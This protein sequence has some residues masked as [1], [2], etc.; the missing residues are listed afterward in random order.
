[1]IKAK[2]LTLDTEVTDKLDKLLSKEGKSISS[3][4]REFLKKELK[5][6]LK[7]G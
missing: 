5:K 6:R 4:T 1:M 7:N 3:I 2:N